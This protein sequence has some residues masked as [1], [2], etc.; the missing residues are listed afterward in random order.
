MAIE[1]TTAVAIAFLLMA[2][3]NVSLMAWLWRFP[4]DQSGISTAPRLW[5]NVHR[6]I[7]YL[8]LLTYI[9]MLTVMVPK[10]L[11]YREFTAASCIHIAAG[12]LFGP[13]LLSKI[14]VIRV[15][16]ALG[17]KL[18][19]FGGTLLVGTI[20]LVASVIIPAIKLSS[21]PSSAGKAVATT[22]C[23]QCHGASRIMSETRSQKGW[24][25][26]GHEMAEIAEKFGRALTE[27]EAELAAAYLY[28]I[29]PGTKGGD[30]SGKGRRGRGRG[31]DSRER[32]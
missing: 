23:I 30:D 4:L 1:T 27:E 5:V 18:P 11:A 9:V 7:G 8:F 19:W 2:V 29:A 22:K 28:R 14:L 6:T 16:K 26:I 24:Q 10:A 20:V 13:V 15:F 12:V 32:D 25:E 17:G 21:G 31:R 3:V